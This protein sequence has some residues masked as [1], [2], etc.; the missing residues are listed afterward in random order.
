MSVMTFLY[1][2]QLLAKKDEEC[3][4]DQTFMRNNA[5][6]IQMQPSSYAAVS[7][8]RQYAPQW[9]LNF[10]MCKQDLFLLNPKILI[11]TCFPVEMAGVKKGQMTYRVRRAP[12][13]PPITAALNRLGPTER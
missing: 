6:K 5:Y 11:P 8:S 10:Y 1:T 3:V 7:C 9:E 4:W 13:S 12:P 2:R